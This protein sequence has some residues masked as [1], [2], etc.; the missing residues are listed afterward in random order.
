VGVVQETSRNVRGVV[1][2]RSR[3]K[4]S[5]APP[6]FH[7]QP[8]FEVRDE[9]HCTAGFYL[10]K[11][12]PEGIPEVAQGVRFEMAGCAFSS[13]EI[14]KDSS[15]DFMSTPAQ[16]SYFRR[17]NTDG[18]VILGNDTDGCVATRRQI[19]P[20]T[21]P[22]DE[23]TFS[24]HLLSLHHSDY[25]TGILI[26]GMHKACPGAQILVKASKHQSKLF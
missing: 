4:M 22:E 13:C 24:E 19:V 25:C 3:T 23:L 12:L 7:E 21:T 11:E 6:R 16:L 18:H 20:G 10:G 17:R 5:Q 1:R 15:F 26:F 8:R 2:Y 9:S 14:F